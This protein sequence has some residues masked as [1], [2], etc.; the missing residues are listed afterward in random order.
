MGDKIDALDLQFAIMVTETGAV[1][2]GVSGIAF[3]RSRPASWIIARPK[4]K[5]F[6]IDLDE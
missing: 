6:V 4:R 1:W 3:P 5:L 2:S